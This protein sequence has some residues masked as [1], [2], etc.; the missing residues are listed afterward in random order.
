MSEKKKFSYY[1]KL[2]AYKKK[3]YD[4]SNLITKIDIPLKERFIPYLNYLKNC[5]E[6]GNR[7]KTEEASQKVVL[8]LCRVFNVSG[9][10]V[11]VFEARPNNDYGE[12]HGLYEREISSTKAV[13]SLW[14][15]TAKKGQIVSY[16]TYLRTL[17][18]EVLHHLDYSHFRLNESFHTQGFYLRENHLYKQLIGLIEIK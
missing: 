3:I 12:L 14:M 6:S 11:K 18:H 17:V 7:L 5:L 15:R 16:K 4:Q 9:V 8:G 10:K 13:I 2:P 1:K